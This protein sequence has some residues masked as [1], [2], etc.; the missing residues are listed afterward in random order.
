VEQLKKQYTP[1]SIKRPDFWGGYILT[2]DYYEFWQGRKNRLHD[3]ISYSLKAP[4][5]IIERLAP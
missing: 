4:N 3:R 1:E 2:A 5:W